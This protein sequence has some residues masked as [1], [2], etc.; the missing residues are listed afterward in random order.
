MVPNFWHQGLVSWRWVFLWQGVG[1]S[2]WDSSAL[3]LLC[4]F[5]LLPLLISQEALVHDLEVEDLWG[6]L[7]LQWSFRDHSKQ[8][9]GLC[10]LISTSHLVCVPSGKEKYWVKQFLWLR[11]LFREMQLWTMS[12]HLTFPATGRMSAS[13][14]KVHLSKPDDSGPFIEKIFLFPLFCSATFVINQVTK[15]VGLVLKSFLL[16]SLPILRQ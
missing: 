2:F 8:A 5:Y 7:E 14:L 6:A 13:V 11:E 1:G 9:P 16:V 3:H 12:S 15:C 10:I 4:T